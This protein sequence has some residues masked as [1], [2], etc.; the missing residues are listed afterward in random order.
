MIGK[1]SPVSLSIVG[2]H[3]IHSS[4]HFAYS[5]CENP[6]SFPH[7]VDCSLH[8]LIDRYENNDAPGTGALM[9]MNIGA[10]RS[11]TSGPIG[12]DNC[13]E[14][15]VPGQIGTYTDFCMMWLWWRI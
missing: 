5:Y 11:E 15:I 13:V 6:C 10:M 2:L 14:V 8:A 4:L 12:K 1:V 3:I 9:T 7:F